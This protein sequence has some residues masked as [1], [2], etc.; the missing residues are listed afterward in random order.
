LKSLIWILQT[1]KK[2]VIPLR[3]NLLIVSPQGL[4][5]CNRS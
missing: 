1:T 5:E 3:Y 4:G 2:L